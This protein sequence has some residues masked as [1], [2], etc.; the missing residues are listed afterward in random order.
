MKTERL[1]LW[2]YLLS[3]VAVASLGSLVWQMMNP[4]PGRPYRTACMSS[5][6]Q[7]GLAFAIYQADYDEHFPSFRWMDDLKEYVKQ[8]EI[9][10]C[11]T[12]EKPNEFGR[13]MNPRL[14][15]QPAPVDPAKSVLQ[16]ESP[17]LFRNALAT[18]V[19]PLPESRH[20]GNNAVVFADSHVKMCV[21]AKAKEISLEVSFPPKDA[22]SGRP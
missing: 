21:P 1:G 16:L 6:K 3:V 17:S 4:F 22:H 20:G 11:S 9:F 7:N 10:R 8:P 19:E 18:D 13:A 2:H 12:I 5:A 15:Y 14:A